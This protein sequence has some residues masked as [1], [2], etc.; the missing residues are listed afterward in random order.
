MEEIN[1]KSGRNFGILSILLLQAVFV[2][3]TGQTK[4]QLD[5]SALKVTEINYHPKDVISGVDTVSGKSFE[6]IEFK[7][8]GEVALDLSGITIDSAITFVFPYNTILE[9]GKFYVIATK[10][11]YFFETYAKL[12]S[13]NC[14]GFFDNA[15]DSIVVRD[16]QKNTIIA[17]RYNDKSPW[18]ETPDGD[19]T[20]LTSVER[21][22]TGNPNDYSYWTASTTIGGSPFSDDYQYGTTIRNTT[23]DFKK[24]YNLYPNPT[25]QYLNIKANPD[26]NGNKY[27]SYKIYNMDGSVIHEDQ[28]TDETRIDL[29]SLGLPIGIYM[30]KIKSDSYIQTEKLIF[31]P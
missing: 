4:M 7:N 3:L 17:F 26:F 30:L 5:Y 23:S 13:G 8:T 10:P 24:E 2:S 31:Q 12:P 27:A 28:I 6:F 20:S 15:G 1:V 16:A 22:P 14:D 11:T 9:P 18:P 29:N 21:N 19:G 25:S